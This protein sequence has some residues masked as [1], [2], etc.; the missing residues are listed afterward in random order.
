MSAPWLQVSIAEQRLGL[1]DASGCQRVWPVSTALKG[2]G[3]AQGSWQTPLGWH[4]IRARIGSHCAVNSV[5]VGRRPTGEIYSSA[6]G[7]QHPNRDWILTRILWLC[8]EETGVNRGGMVDSQRRYIYI[9]GTP[10]TE[11]MGTPRSHGCVRMR[12]CD[13][14]ALYDN[15]AVGMKVLISPDSLPG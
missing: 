8:G 2:A 12:N 7:A 6:L 9:H 13:I 15:V 11:P 14:L 4:R 5:F 3:N 1:F 10:D